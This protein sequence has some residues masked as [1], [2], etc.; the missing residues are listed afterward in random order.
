LQLP[1]KEN[2]QNYLEEDRLYLSEKFEEY[3]TFLTQKKHNLKIKEEDAKKKFSINLDNLKYASS[4]LN[5]VTSVQQKVNLNEEVDTQ[6]L[7]AI[8][9]AQRHV[10]EQ[11]L[12]KKDILLDDKFSNLLENEF[13]LEENNP[14]NFVKNEILK[15]TKFKENILVFK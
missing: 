5:P 14:L 3:G 13:Q 10:Y 8:Q 15:T 4:K 1:D 6:K 2:I 7:I 11:R 9:K 12:K